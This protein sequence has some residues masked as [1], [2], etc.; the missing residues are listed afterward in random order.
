MTETTGVG[1]QV[2]EG[3]DVV[4]GVVCAD[5]VVEGVVCADDVVE[6]V[7][8][9]VDVGVGVDVVSGVRVIETGIYRLAVDVST[10]GVWEKGSQ[11]RTLANS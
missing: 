7:V 11:F 8:C 4:E 1:V 3:D 6:G 2:K 10:E 5:D 9:G